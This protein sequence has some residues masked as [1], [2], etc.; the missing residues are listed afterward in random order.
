M[1]INEFKERKMNGI[2]TKDEFLNYITGKEID[3]DDIITLFF[4][5]YITREM[6]GTLYSESDYLPQNLIKIYYSNV[7]VPRFQKILSNFK[8]E[9]I[10]SESNL[11]DVH[12]VEE[13]EGLGLVYDYIE[14]EDADEN[15]N[16]YNLLKI[17][18]ILFSKCPCPEFGGKFRT[19]EIYLPNSGVETSD[20]R[21]LPK[22][23]AQLYQ[24]VNQLIKDGIK[25]GKRRNPDKIIEYINDCLELNAKIIGMHP[26]GDGNGRATRA[27]TNLMFKIA[28]I[29][30]VYIRSSDKDAYG[31]AMNKAIVEKDFQSLRKFYYYKICDSIIELDILKRKNTEMICE[32]NRQGKS[33]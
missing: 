10:L 11:E 9:Y 17:H 4:L 8:E 6:N 24:P 7:S 19:E 31:R 29:P 28:N 15:L 33:K 27:F 18:Q 32:E 21:N 26:F 5:N 16:I 13:R 14:S 30:P 20:W 23:F 2:T 3:M 25:L 22:E 12:T 1:G